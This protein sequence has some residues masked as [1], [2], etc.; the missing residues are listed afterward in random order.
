MTMTEEN[1]ETPEISLV[2]AV[3][4]NGIIGVDGDMP[5]HLPEDMAHFKETTSGHP[6]VM[7]RKTYRSIERGL[8]GP[9]P[10]RTNVVLS[11]GSPD[12]PDG[13]VLVGSVD[14]A[15]DAVRAT[16]D[17][18]AFV[19]GGATVYEQ[20]L[21]HADRL[22]LTEIHDSHDGD[23]SFPEWN[24]TEWTERSRDERGAFD[25]VEYVRTGVDRSSRS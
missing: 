2:A 25:F 24:R 12:L 7:G 9:L 3:A 1:N 8:G 16:G 15:I 10:D 19:A 20:F 6:V 22:I 23:T 13:V 14:E 5:W 17:D 18:V 11:R 4:A 21:P